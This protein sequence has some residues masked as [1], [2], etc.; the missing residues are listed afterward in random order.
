MM[1]CL[2]LFLGI[3]TAAGCCSASDSYPL[4]QNIPNRTIISLNGS[5][6]YIVDPYETGLKAR[7]YLNA[8][9][10]NK[11]D[12][13]EYDFDKSDVLNVPGD[14][15]SQKKELFFYEGPVWYEKSFSYRKREHVRVFM[16]FGAANYSSRVYLNGEA[17]GEHD[18]GFTPFN[19]EITDKIHQGDN[20]LVVEVNNVRRRDA[21]P[22]PNT[23]WWNYGGLTRDVVLV[24]EPETFIQDY[25]VQLA[26]GSNKEISGWVQL[27]GATSAQQVTV[28]IPEAG[29]KKTVTADAAGRAE[30]HSPAKLELWSPAHPKLYE[31]ILSSAADRGHP[32]PA[33][34]QTHFPPRHI[35]A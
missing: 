6:H 18:G 2:H 10:K 13:V 30:F 14:W 24:E 31:V 28:N 32:N 20:F 35:H 15:N 5:W 7:F 16:S 26:K 29:V 3:L 25:V 9:A 33:Q 22:A 12:L 4:I 34:R 17:L 21:V 1:R 11:Q 8:K 19:F 23:D 27:D